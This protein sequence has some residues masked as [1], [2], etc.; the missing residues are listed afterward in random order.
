MQR[1]LILLVFMLLL[2]GLLFAQSDEILISCQPSQIF[3][4]SLNT[5]SF[6]PV[7]PQNQ[8][9]LTTITISNISQP[10]QPY[11]YDME[12][13]IKWNS[14]QIVDVKFHSLSQ[15]HP[16][17]PAVFTNRDLITQNASTSFSSPDGDISITEIMDQNPVLRDALQSG[18]FPDGTITFEMTATPL[19]ASGQSSTASFSVKVKNINAIFLTYPGKPCGQTSN[20]ISMR[21][22]TFLWNVVN[23][24]IENNKYR[25]VIKEFERDNIPNS[26]NVETSGNVIFDRLLTENL[27]SDFLPFQDH[28]YYAW[29]VSTGLFNESHTNWI[30]PD[31]THDTQPSSFMKSEWFTFKYVADQNASGGSSQQMMAILNSLRDPAIQNLLAQGY[32]LTGVVVYEGQVYTGQEAIDLINSLLGKNLEIEIKEQ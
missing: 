17:I 13:V 27:F 11:K 24:G 16:G 10:P 30:P 26:S 23:T 29:Q 25:L 3:V 15:L 18:F 2:G 22:V 5:G 7:N 32:E 31:P 9:V 4:N 21:P 1:I 14:T 19:T 8:P 20:V 28:H 12:I 6:D